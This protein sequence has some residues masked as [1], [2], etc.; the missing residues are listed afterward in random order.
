MEQRKECEHDGCN[1]EL[2][3]ARFCPHHTNLFKIESYA[4]GTCKNEA[5]AKPSR[6]NGGLCQT[7]YAES[8]RRKNGIL[9]KGSEKE[10][11][12]CKTEGCS[13]N[14]RAK[15]MCRNCYSKDR[16]GITPG[17]GRIKG[18]RGHSSINGS[19]YVII[20][21]PELAKEWGLTGWYVLEHRLIMSE[22]LGRMLTEEENV[23]HI[24]GIRHDNR[25]ENLELWSTSQ[26]YGQRVADKIEWA[27]SILEK[28][29]EDLENGKL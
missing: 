5:C 21:N 15:G 4:Y 18:Q 1:K 6:G 29:K 28:Y 14:V 10:P 27:K 23:H 24:N 16:N 8:R 9:P 20:Y 12:K 26:P 19:G 11:Q 7:H 13:R 25:I 3:R 17:T 22:H 2:L